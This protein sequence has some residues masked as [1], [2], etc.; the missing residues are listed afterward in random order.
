MGRMERETGGASSP[1]LSL[2]AIKTLRAQEPCVRGAGQRPACHRTA[3][4]QMHRCLSD[5]TKS[6]CSD[7]YLNPSL[8]PNSGLCSGVNKESIMHRQVLPSKCSAV[9]RLLASSKYS[10]PSLHIPHQQIPLLGETYL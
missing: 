3:I 4:T 7:S 6:P 2:R 8:G 1:E 5:W 10:R 9:G